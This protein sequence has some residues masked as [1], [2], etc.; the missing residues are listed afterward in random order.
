MFY[1]LGEI[2]ARRDPAQSPGEHLELV[3]RALE[4]AVELRVAAGVVA[5][6]EANHK[7][8]LGTSGL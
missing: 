8:L 5:Q 2:D 6:S 1:V 3:V 4:A 7:L